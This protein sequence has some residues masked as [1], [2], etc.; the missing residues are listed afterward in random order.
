[1][2]A[3]SAVAGSTRGETGA[4]ESRRRKEISMLCVEFCRVTALM[5]D[6]VEVG[7]RWDFRSSRGACRRHRLG[8]RQRR[9]MSWHHTTV[10]VQNWMLAHRPFSPREDRQRPSTR[11]QWNSNLGC[12]FPCEHGQG[13]QDASFQPSRSSI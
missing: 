1:M 8:C 6:K 9:S 11:H 12:T 13:H 5:E 10:W 3:F 4:A 7:P 2:C